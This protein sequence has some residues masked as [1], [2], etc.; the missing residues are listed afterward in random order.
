MKKII[1][2]GFIVVDGK[3]YCWD[4]NIGKMIGVNAI[5]TSLNVAEN[6]CG[7]IGHKWEVQLFVRPCEVVFKL[8]KQL[9]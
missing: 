6:E 3:G 5:Y 9:W 1:K 7:A 8:E 4:F 2:K